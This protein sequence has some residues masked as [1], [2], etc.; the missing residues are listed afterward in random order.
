MRLTAKRE[1]RGAS[2]VRDGMEGLPPVPEHARNY[3]QKLKDG[4]AETPLAQ[5]R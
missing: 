4:R 3:P 2:Y 5:R 1:K